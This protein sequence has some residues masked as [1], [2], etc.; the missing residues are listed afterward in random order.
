MLLWVTAQTPGTPDKSG[1]TM[2]E[3]DEK[4]AR[5]MAALYLRSRLEAVALQ[6]H[7]LS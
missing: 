7:K 5:H 6:I 3:A 1:K 4:A 2:A